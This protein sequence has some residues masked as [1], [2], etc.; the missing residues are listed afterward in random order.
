MW[1]ALPSA[2]RTDEAFAVDLRQEMI[3]LKS[4]LAMPLGSL[5]IISPLPLPY[6]LRAIVTV[7]TLF[8]GDENL[9]HYRRPRIGE[10]GDGLS[11]KAFGAI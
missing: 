7:S 5:L 10:D 1:F 8:S 9:L 3:Q 4:R 2:L 6:Q 11:D